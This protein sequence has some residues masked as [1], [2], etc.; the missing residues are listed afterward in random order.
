[1][2]SSHARSTGTVQLDETKADTND[3]EED[4]DLVGDT[5]A[6]SARATK[7]SNNFFFVLVQGLVQRLPNRSVNVFSRVFVER[8]GRAS[9]AF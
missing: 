1:M 8:F 3:C 4:E 7:L 9:R 6:H 2:P 5:K